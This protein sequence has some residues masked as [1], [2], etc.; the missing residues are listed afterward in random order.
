MN[1]SLKL[2]YDPLIPPKIRRLLDQELVVPLT[3]KS[4][5]RTI[6]HEE[7]S[8]PLRGLA[9]LTVDPQP[10][11][12]VNRLE[13]R[14]R[15]HQRLLR[16]ALVNTAHR[17]WQCHPSTI[18]PYLQLQPTT[19]R[20]T[21]RSFLPNRQLQLDL[22]MLDHCSRILQRITEPLKIPGRDLNHSPR[23]M[24]QRKVDR[25]RKER[26]AVIDH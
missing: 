4:I 8:L 19:F 1:H 22:G 14:S 12:L 2:R 21:E 24:V 26:M 15:I 23:R 18:L 7:T 10:R 3:S 9:D 11:T 17:R 25:N 6:N 16:F 5:R 20:N 13:A